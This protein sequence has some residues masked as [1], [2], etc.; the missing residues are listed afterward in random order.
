MDLRKTVAGGAGRCPF[1]P[2]NAPVSRMRV[3]SLCRFFLLLVFERMR[4]LFERV[5]RLNIRR[6][7][8]GGARMERENIAR[9]AKGDANAF[10]ALMGAYE[11]KIYALCL[12]MMGNPHDGED[13]G[14]RK[15]CCAFGAPIGQY[16]FE[17]AFST[18]IYRV[19]ASCCMDAI[20]KRQRHAQPSLEEMGETDGFDPADS[21][22]TRTGACRTD[23]DE[24][25]DSAGD[26]RRAGN[27]ARGLSAAGCTRPQRGRDGAGAANC[28]RYGE[29]AVG[30]GEREDCRRAETARRGRNGR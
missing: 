7:A 24:K 12:R 26:F 10:E 27:D 25:R 21:G 15:R 4:E 30:A 16:R 19:T 2:K 14:R 23:G 5:I 17:S 29:V 9:A 13:A 6:N 1:S 8:K 3:R 20:R 11:T 22:E 28:A 18:W